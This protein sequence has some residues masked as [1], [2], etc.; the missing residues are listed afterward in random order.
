MEDYKDSNEFW[1]FGED[2]LKHRHFLIPDN[3]IHI[4]IKPTQYMNRDT[5]KPGQVRTKYLSFKQLQDVIPTF[6][7]K[8]QLQLDVNTIDEKR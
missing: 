3:F 7:T 4:K 6:S 1:I 5:G 2:Y 8:L